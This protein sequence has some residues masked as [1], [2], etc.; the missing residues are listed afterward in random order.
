MS[1]VS[2]PGFA[3]PYPFSSKFGQVREGL[4]SRDKEEKATLKEFSEILTNLNDAIIYSAPLATNSL[5]VPTFSSVDVKLSSFYQFGAFEVQWCDVVGFS[6]EFAN[7]RAQF[8]DTSNCLTTRQRESFNDVPVRE[9]GSTMESY[10]HTKQ[11]VGSLTFMRV[12]SPRETYNTKP[13]MRPLENRHLDGIYL[14]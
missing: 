1:I 6:R 9:S 5:R 11:L 7:A 14:I 12:V 10:L 13:T 2:G 4:H 8:S 3:I